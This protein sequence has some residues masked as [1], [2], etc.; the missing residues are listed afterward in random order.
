[1]LGTKI[2]V[3]SVASLFFYIMCKETRTSLSV[4]LIG[5]VAL[6]LRLFVI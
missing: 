2:L 1:M 5:I 6:S 4:G 3:L